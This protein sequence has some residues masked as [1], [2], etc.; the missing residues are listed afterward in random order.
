MFD[1]SSLSP[2]DRRHF[3]R[4]TAI[5]ALCLLL[6]A[7]LHLFRVVMYDQT[8]WKGG[9]FGMFS[10]VDAETARYVE[11]YL[12][13]PEQGYRTSIPVSL[14][15]SLRKKEAELRAL[16]NIE[17][18]KELATRM[19]RLRYEPPG[20]RIGN[21]VGLHIVSADDLENGAAQKY[22]FPECQG[23]YW[24]PVSSPTDAGVAP[25]GVTITVWRHVYD[26]STNQLAAKKILVTSVSAKD[27]PEKHDVD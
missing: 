2:A 27:L 8:R 15:E 25:K 4:R 10:T 3:Y 16:P 22:I 13:V 20:A 18:A 6:V 7:G 26:R 12:D 5:P 1:P 19:C 11:V 24:E 9:G 14:P 23:Q 21:L 17:V